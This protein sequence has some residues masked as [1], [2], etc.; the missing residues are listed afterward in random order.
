MA[1]TDDS[2]LICA[3]F[4]CYKLVPVKNSKWSALNG[5]NQ[6]E[7]IGVVW[8][9]MSTDLHELQQVAEDVVIFQSLQLPDSHRANL[10]IRVVAVQQLHGQPHVQAAKNRSAMRQRVS[11]PKNR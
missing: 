6:L 1:A 3:T 7:A 11:Q 8:F 10:G 5:T 2:S 9:V 4:C